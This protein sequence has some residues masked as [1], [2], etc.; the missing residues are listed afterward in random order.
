M[1]A[2]TVPCVL[3]IDDHVMFRAGLSLVITTTIP[4][5]RILE[6]GSLNEALKYTVER[7]DVV[8]LDIKLNGLSGLEGIGLL[9]RQWPLTPIL[10]LSSQTEPDTV[11]LAL[12]R[13]AAGFMSK[14][15][16]VEKMIDAIQQV[17][18]GHFSALAP[19][20]A[21]TAQRRLTPRQCE[22]LELLHQ[23]LSNKL[24]ARHLKLSD[25]TV[26]R[27]VQDILEFFGV[28]NRSEAVYA[29]YHQGLIG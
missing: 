19:P 7:I 20:P 3:L 18:R 6:A 4:G 5:T 8:L 10:M 24:I 12:E 25:N 15:D 21:C 9:Q 14:A 29:A 1:A 27:H 16:T 28:S 17:L 11:R 2:M 13:G 23:G 26:R 22:V